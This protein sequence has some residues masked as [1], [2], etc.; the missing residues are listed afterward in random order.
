[1]TKRKYNFYSLVVNEHDIT[2]GCEEKIVEALKH[3]DEVIKPKAIMLVTTC[4]LEVIGEDVVGIKTLI[5]DDLNAKLLVVNTEHFKCSNHI[6]GME[7]SLAALMTLME[8]QEVEAGSVNIL[9]YRQHDIEKTELY[10]MLI[11]EHVK[12]NTILPAETSIESLITTPRA[13]LNIVTEFIALPL[14][15][16]MEKKFG[17]PFVYFDKNLSID[18][19]KTGY[20]EMEAI[21]KINITEK[22]KIRITKSNDK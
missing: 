6:S 17:T 2:F 19:I 1:M 22:L 4:V 5:Q 12:I 7:D 21:L 8:P 15:E 9:G 3:L 14:A 10:N 11:S 20:E 18:I 16:A 13:S